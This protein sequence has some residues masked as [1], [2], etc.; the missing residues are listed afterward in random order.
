MATQPTF[1]DATLGLRRMEQN[2]R[3]LRIHLQETLEAYQ[4]LTEANQRL[5]AG[6]NQVYTMAED[7][8]VS[9]ETSTATYDKLVKVVD[10]ISCTK[11]AAS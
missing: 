3:R 1:D 8:L 7:I 10:V 2:Y 5:T 6:L 4:K 11:R 9:R